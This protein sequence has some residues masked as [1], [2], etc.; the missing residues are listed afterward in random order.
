M[1]FKNGLSAINLEMPD[2]IPRF[3]PS[4]GEYHWDLIKAVT[5]LEVDIDSPEEERTKATQAFIKAWDYG[6]YFGCLVS[7]KEHGNIRTNMGHAEYAQR[8]RDFDND[9]RCPFKTPEEVLSFDPW[10]TYG[11]KEHSELVNRFNEH[12]RQQCNLFPDTVNTTGIYVTL[13]SGMISIFGWDL[14]L[15]AAG[16]DSK[17]FGELVNRYADWIK[18][19][20]DAVAES[21]TTVIYSHDDIVWT[22]GPFI[23]PEWYRKY[24][25]PNFEKLWDKPRRNGKKVMYVC[26]GNYTQFID[27]IATCGNAGFWFEIFTDLEYVTKKYGKTHF[28]IGNGDA[29]VLTFGTKEAIR[30]EVKRCIDAGRD[31][32]GYFM[33]IS[34]HI[35]PN[36]PV[37]NAL[38]Y[39]DVYQEL[40]RR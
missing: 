8:G 11:E 20:Y 22:E 40:A 32:P 26:D 18:Q 21:E 24:I 6:I 25:F 2:V 27:D 34:G 39:N 37:E 30:A 29:R 7:N 10:E 9:L 19:Y 5:G 14:L 1:S 3:E 17:R 36:V 16:E 23:N 28:I 31:C 35:P 13:M 33:C 38:Y 4:A 12:Y 15:L